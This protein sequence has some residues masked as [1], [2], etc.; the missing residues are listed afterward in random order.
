MAYLLRGRGESGAVEIE[1]EAG[2]RIV[3]CFDGRR[4]LSYIDTRASNRQCT[5][6]NKSI[7]KGFFT[8]KE[9]TKTQTKTN[10]N[11]NKNKFNVCE[12]HVR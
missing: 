1:S 2:K 8:K 4:L 7:N 3:V 12:G 6:H 5:D 10:A 9:K 11:T